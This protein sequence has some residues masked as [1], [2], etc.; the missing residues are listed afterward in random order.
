MRGLRLLA[1][2]RR[3]G[4]SATDERAEM[5][6]RGRGATMRG[7]R[8]LTLARRG[9]ESATDERVAMRSTRSRRDDARMAT[10]CSRAARRRER[11]R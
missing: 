11:D 1:L 2:A 3:G 10:T 4:E 7:L 8:L 5:T 9:G 6:A